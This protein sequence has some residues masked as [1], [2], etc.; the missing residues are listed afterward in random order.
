MPVFTKTLKPSL[1]SKTMNANR[2][3]V[4]SDARRMLCVIGLLTAVFAAFLFS[5]KQASMQSDALPVFNSTA[6]PDALGRLAFQ[7]LNFFTSGFATVSLLAV[8]ADGTG[9][10]TLAAAGTP[11]L[12]IGEPAFSSDGAKIAYVQDSDIYVMNSDGSNKINITNNNFMIVERNP[13]WSATGRIA[14][15]RDSKIWT[16][17]PDGSNQTHFSAITQSSPLAP[18]WSPDGREIVFANDKEDGATGN[19]EIFKLEIETGESEK[20][21]TFRRR[22]DIYPVFSPDGKHIAFASNTDGNAEIYLMNA[23]GTGLLRLT[24]NLANDSTPQFSKDGKKIIFSS[25]RNGK[26]ALY[27]I[28][29]GDVNQ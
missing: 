9:L 22:A 20:R 18:A 21:L 17:N 1:W 15:E 23:D 19:F 6:Q 4:V 12:F 24:R 26:F 7:R 16:I 13:S 11:P 10:T 28:F 8:N 3:T 2:S 25:N 14:Y 5:T 29:I 27:E